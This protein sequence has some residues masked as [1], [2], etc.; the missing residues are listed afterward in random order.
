MTEQAKSMV[1]TE[2]SKLATY[3]ADYWMNH[4]DRS[5]KADMD[6]LYRHV[7]EAFKHVRG[8]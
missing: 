5:S 1:D 6:I 4:F 2:L 8:E 3:Y 7:F